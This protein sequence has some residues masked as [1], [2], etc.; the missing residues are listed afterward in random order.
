MKD[1]TAL[2]LVLLLGALT[3]GGLGGVGLLR[4]TSTRTLSGAASLALLAAV[5]LLVAALALL[6][7]SRD[8]TPP[9]FCT[10]CHAVLG[11]GEPPCGSCGHTP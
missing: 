6:A 1:R 4:G 9:R 2:A 7:S 3:A 5:V 8:T 10:R 11:P